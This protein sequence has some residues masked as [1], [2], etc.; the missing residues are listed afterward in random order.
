MTVSTDINWARVRAL[1]DGE[2]WEKVEPQRWERQVCIGTVFGLFPS[3]KYYTP[4]ASSGVAPCPQCHGSRKAGALP[5]R[6][7][8]KLVRRLV[9]LNLACGKRDLNYV[10]RIRAARFRLSSRLCAGRCPSCGGCGS[11]E[12][13]LDEQYRALLE[14]EAAERDLYV[15]EGE[16]DPCDVL[17]GEYTEDDPHE[18]EDDETED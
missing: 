15:T 9:R 2:D 14:S 5:R 10:L 8:K 4:W 17:V 7:H 18:G 12:A 13:H 11:R 6:L 1:L 3:G 16:G